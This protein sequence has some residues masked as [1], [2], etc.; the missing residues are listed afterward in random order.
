ME[1]N[2]EEKSPNPNETD[3]LIRT[4]ASEAVQSYFASPGEE[5][6]LQDVGSENLYEPL[7]NSMMRLFNRE[8][9]SFSSPSKSVGTLVGSFF[10]YIFLSYLTEN[11]ISI[12]CYLMIFA[13][14][15]AAGASFAIK[16]FLQVEP[17]DIMNSVIPTERPFIPFLNEVV[18]KLV[19]LVDEMF[20]KIF[21]LIRNGDGIDY[22]A[23][24]IVLFVTALLLQ[25]TNLVKGFFLIFWAQFVIVP[26][27]EKFGNLITT[28]YKQTKE[29]IR[30]K[31]NKNKL[32]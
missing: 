31:L 4:K 29:K 6:L 28:C 13:I 5:T 14:L 20:G 25:R 11:I 7:D 10:L 1:L 3:D 18:E 22:A 12:L 21:A 32:N 24:V 27:E 15:A 8:T 16:K 19:E 26:A 9:F 23:A 2:T 30:S 17:Q